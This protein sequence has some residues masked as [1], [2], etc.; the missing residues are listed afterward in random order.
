MS[1]KDTY[2]VVTRASDGTF[3]IRD[4]PSPEPI[5]E[6]HTQIGVDDSSADLALRGMPV[7][8]GLVGPIPEGKNV[9][10]YESPEV[11]EAVTKE[12]SNKKIKRRRRRRPEIEAAQEAEAEA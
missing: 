4:F 6:I 10:R 3:R 2:R 11:F 5:H 9:V 1:S 8:R 7:F 12:W